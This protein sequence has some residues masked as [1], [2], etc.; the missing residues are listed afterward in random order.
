MDLPRPKLAEAGL[1][2][3]LVASPLLVTPFTAS[4]FGVSK[5][6]PVVAGSLLIWLARP[7][8]ERRIVWFA[9]AWIG[10]TVLAALFGVEPATGLTTA[11]RSSGGGLIITLTTSTLI[12]AGSG[13]PDAF[14]DRAARLLLGAGLAVSAIGIVF[15]AFPELPQPILGGASANAATFGNTLFAVAFV[16]AAAATVPGRLGARREIL[17]IAVL[18]LGAASFGERSSYLLPLVAILVASRRGRVGAARTGVLAATT[19]AILVAWAVAEPHL[20][21]RPGSNSS[22]SQFVDRS[23][24]SAR[25]TVW[26]A[27]YQGWTQRP[28]F[29]WGPGATRTAYIRGATPQQLEEASR[30]WADAH[31]LPLE[32]LVSGGLVRFLPFLALAVL[33]AF[34][35]WR[36]PPECAWALGAT[37]AL[38]GYALFEP[39][40]PLLTPMLGLTSALAARSP[41]G[42][43]AP[44]GDPRFPRSV[45]TIAL[46]VA[47]V[48]TAL[49]TTASTLERWGTRYGQIWALRASVAVQPWRLSA[50]VALAFRLGFDGR[51]SEPGAA[52]AAAEARE[53]MAEAVR[54]HPWDVQV[55]L[56]AADLEVYLRDPDAGRRWVVE[57]VER[58]PSDRA[59]LEAFDRFVAG[60]TPGFPVTSP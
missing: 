48:I 5:L 36:G 38:G 30:R 42:D 60:G 47:L 34:R 29:G 44:V 43:A 18:V 14:A 35:A 28:I 40:H 31:D 6:V 12:V 50:K 8:I 22:V 10:A 17:A 4:A 15:R 56:S 49:M 27:V 57:H 9:G 16:A 59:A 21:R 55:R 26:A 13:A 19:I 2:L 37:A 25:F 41:D 33:L 7:R 54:S 24:D 23:V 3:I 51:G 58:F 53:I 39:I 32:Q 52:Q 11:T 45:A 1:F 20:P 46:V